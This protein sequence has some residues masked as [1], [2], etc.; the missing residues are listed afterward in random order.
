LSNLYTSTIYT[1]FF[2]SRVGT[3]NYALP[4]III[5]N[6]RSSLDIWTVV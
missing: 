3:A 1:R 4:F 6:Y 5:S 2:Q